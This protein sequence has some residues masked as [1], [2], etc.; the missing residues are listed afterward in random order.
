MNKASFFP[1]RQAMEADMRMPNALHGRPAHVLSTHVLDTTMFWSPTGG[2]VRRYLLRK[3]AWLSGRSG[4]RHTILAPG[5]AAPGMVDCGGFPLPLSGGY[6]LP[7]R[8]DYAAAL[9]EGLR[10]DLIEAGDPYRLAW[11]ALDAA[12]RLGVPAIAFCHS[13]LAAMA[14]H[15]SGGEGA[16]ATLAR[17]TAEAYLRR[18][19]R[20][21]DVVLAPSRSMANELQRLGVE[22]V[23][24]QPLG[25]DCL[26]YRPD[27]CD[28]MW[29]QS[30]GLPSRARLLLYA[31]RFAPEK[32]LPVLAEAVERLGAPYYLLAVGRGPLPPQGERVIVLPHV[33]REEELACIYA[34]VDAFVHAGD[35]ET[36]GLSVLE[37]MASGTPVAVRAAAG[38]AELVGGAVSGENVSEDLAG[39]AGILVDSADP[40]IW[41]EA[42]TELFDSSRQ[43]RV[44]A[45]RRRAESLDWRCVM[46]AITARYARLIARSRSLRQTRRHDAAE[47]ASGLR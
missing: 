42:M 23:E 3:R 34:S 6:R 1:T 26:I 11:A 10:P 31:G 39:E 21:F 46:P 16:T 33:R 8:R 38:L 7:L 45:A 36:F 30:L 47:W 20:L 14:E 5:A 40:G 18:V 4:W 44:M 32:N 13:N 22:R 24:R 29:R 37:A 12:Q 28:P 9:I 27:R 35:Q 25:V 17:R 15:F 41:A 2:G 19:Y 43:R